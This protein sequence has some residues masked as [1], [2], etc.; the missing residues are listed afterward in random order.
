MSV[1]LVARKNIKDNENI[2]DAELAK[3]EKATGHAHTFEYDVAAVYEALSKKEAGGHKDYIGRVLF[4]DYL[5]GLVSRVE[6]ICKVEKGKECWNN[7]VTA[8]KI[9]LEVNA[10]KAP[11]IN[12]VSEVVDGVYKIYVND[13]KG[14]RN[15]AFPA[16]VGDV[17][18]KEMPRILTTQNLPWIVWKSIN[19][20]ADDRVKVEEKINKAVGAPVE[21]DIPWGDVWEALKNAPHGEHTAMYM[22]SIKSG[23]LSKLTYYLEKLTKDEMSKEALMEKWTKKKIVFVV[24]GAKNPGTTPITKFEDGVMVIYLND[25]KAK[26]GQFPAMVD[27]CG[28]D[29]EKQL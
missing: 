10:Q 15:D 12:P 19:Q 6:P 23:Y 4:K 21:V 29:I 17:G 11:D 25:N 5:G 13:N 27:N 2:R 8:K 16:M 9:V 24:D 1:P 14:K 20:Y 22:V 3:L 18:A 26:A 7:T 28:A